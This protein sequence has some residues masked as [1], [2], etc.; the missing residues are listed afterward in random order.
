MNRYDN[1]PEILAEAIAQRMIE[2]GAAEKVKSSVLAKLAKH[3]EQKRKSRRERVLVAIAIWWIG[4]SFGFWIGGK[5]PFAIAQSEGNRITAPKESVTQP[6]LLRITLTLSDPKDLKVK[7]KD[8]LQKD[9]IISDRTDERTRLQ[10]Q[11]SEYLAT[12]KRLSLEPSKP[13]EP[14]A[15]RKAPELP[16]QSFAEFESEVDFQRIKVERA[17]NQ[18][19]LQQRKIDLIATLDAKD[20]PSGVEAHESEKLAQVKSDLAKEEAMLQLQ[21][22]KFETAKANRALKEYD[23]QE[24]SVRLALQ[25]NQTQMEYQ[26]ALAEYNRSE[27]ERQFRIAEIRSKIADV[28]NKLQE[29]STIRAQFASEVRRIRYVKQVNNAIELELFLYAADRND[30]RIRTNSKGSSPAT[31]NQESFTKPN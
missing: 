21:L 6:R 5:L 10:A 19:S 26:K 1:L 4:G 7:E 16:P 13:I 18:V 28:E 31:F 22:G 3:R 29:L 23:S 20:L 2:S 14:L 30:R 27:Q 15:V 9:A 24:A 12:I 11:R 8:F 25:Q 17:K